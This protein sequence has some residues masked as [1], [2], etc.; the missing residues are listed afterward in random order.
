MYDRLL[1]GEGRRNKQ[2]KRARQFYDHRRAKL[3]RYLRR[4]DF[5]RYFDLIKALGMEDD[6]APIT[7]FQK[8]R[9]KLDWKTFEQAKAEG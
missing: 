4:T 1:A 5:P 6:Y 2:L 8:Y 7:Y 9:P 3:L